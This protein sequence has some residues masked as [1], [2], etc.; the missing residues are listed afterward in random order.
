MSDTQETTKP[1][2]NQAWLNIWIDSEGGLGFEANSSSTT[3]LL[4]MVAL[5]K[6]LIM[7]KALTPKNAEAT[8][9]S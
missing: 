1:A 9:E 5:A 3:Q 6:Q 7:Q 4:G 2:D 8:T